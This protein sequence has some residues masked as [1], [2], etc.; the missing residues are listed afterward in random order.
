M[1]THYLTNQ[2]K[3]FSGFDRFSKFVLIG[4]N[5]DGRVNVWIEKF[6]NYQEAILALPGIFQNLEYEGEWNLSFYQVPDD[7]KIKHLYG[8]YKVPKKGRRVFDFGYMKAGRRNEIFLTPGM[9][10]ITSRSKDFERKWSKKEVQ[11]DYLVYEEFYTTLLREDLNSKSFNKED[12]PGEFKYEN[13]YAWKL[14]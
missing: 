1:V 7:F 14:S 5:I 6:T 3:I 4:N 13:E 8:Y 10:H 11:V 12:Y 9:I 2:T